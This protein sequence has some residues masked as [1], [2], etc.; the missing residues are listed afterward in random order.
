MPSKNYK[1]R[2]FI[3]EST[4]AVFSGI[5]GMDV[6]FG[7]NMPEGYIP[8]L[9]QDRESL[10]S[11]GKNSALIVLNDKPWNVETPA[12]LLDDKI[13]PAD[14]MFIRNNGLLAPKTDPSNWKLTIKGESVLSEKTYTFQE[15]KSKFVSHT[16]QLVLECGG[17]GR[18][19]FYPPTE[20]NQW[21]VG[22]VHCAAW[23]GLRLKD[24]LD[25]VGIKAD[26]VYVGYHGTDV[27]LS[28]DAN[29][30]AISRGIPIG[31]AMQDETLIAYAM[32]GKDIPMVHGYPLRLVASGYPA[33]VSGKW[34][35]A[36]SVRNKV[37]DGSKME[38]PSYMVP[39]TPVEP[40][41]NI[42]DENFQIIESMPVKSLI[43]F[44]K[45][46][47]EFGLTRKLE[48]RGH[49]WAGEK[50]VKSV[51]YSIDFG[52]TWQSCNLESPANRFAWQHFNAQIQFPQKGYY[53]VWAKATDDSGISQPMVVPNWNPKGYL[54]NACHRIAVKVV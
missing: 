33:S 32:N 36:I 15:L 30:E 40:G 20:G 18:G 38:A 45:S 3:K 17:N 41:A 52:S 48:I 14:K 6:V 21:G 27:H 29:R 43:T 49:A 13:T 54:N 1:R 37:H 50:K 4:L 42:S 46:G 11:F 51:S 2:K 39:K 24:L 8:V 53:E 31:K 35:H 7:S 25:D 16:Y 28:G 34:I 26:A 19:E 10:K 23:T 5:L 47:A 9:L 44:P 12:H 22:A